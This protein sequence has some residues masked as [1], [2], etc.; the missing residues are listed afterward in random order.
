M[1][2]TT[3]RCEIFLHHNLKICPLSG[4]VQID[5]LDKGHKGGKRGR[6]MLVKIFRAGEKECAEEDIRPFLL[7]FQYLLL[8]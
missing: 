5:I 2:K 1:D 3:R 6:K 4:K 8:W 7:K